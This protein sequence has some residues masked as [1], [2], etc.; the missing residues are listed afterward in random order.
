VTVP[1]VREEAPADVAEI[2]GV[3][4]CAFADHPHGDQTEHDIVAR[5]RAAVELVLPLVA[6]IDERVAGYA[7]FSQVRLRPENSGWYGLGPIA[8]EPRLQ[9]NGVG[10]ALIEAGLVALKQTGAAGCVVLGE[11][12]YYRRFGFAQTPGLT[13]DGAPAEYFMAQAFRGTVPSASV[14]YHPAFFD[15]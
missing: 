8:V 15:R 7:T 14:F 6:L 1:F 10:T 2:E 12:A 3:L 9:R 5:L 13:F 4:R 11:P